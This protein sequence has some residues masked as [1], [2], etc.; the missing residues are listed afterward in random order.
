MSRSTLLSTLKAVIGSVLLLSFFSAIADST[1]VFQSASPN[2]RLE[3][4]Q[5][6]EIQIAHQ[7]SDRTALAKVKLLFLGDSI[8][9]FWQTGQDLGEKNQ[10]HGKKIWEESFTGTPVEN[11][12]ENFGITGDR[13]EHILYRI[14]PT[15]NGGLG[16]LDSPDL[17]PE[18]II[19]MVGIN[20]SSAPEHPV[21]DSIF[22]GVKAVA[23]A[24]HQRKPHSRII[25]ESLLPTGDPVKNSSVVKPVNQRLAKL[26]EAAEFSGSL[27]YLDLYSSFIKSN[28]KQRVDY[29]VKDGLHPNENGY[30]VWRD[31]LLPFIENDRKNHLH[32]QN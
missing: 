20:N 11:F 6:R 10:W 4:W 9:D 18:Y 22:E 21:A 23:L 30:R 12:A 27:S 2:A 7:L 32:D 25:L 17:N 26:A 3:D 8:T 14:E 15:K 13:T 24:V 19:L 5:Q 29:F 16:E 28:G 1:T 31:H